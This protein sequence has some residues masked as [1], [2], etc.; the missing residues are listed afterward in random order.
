MTL[1]QLPV[2]VCVQISDFPDLQEITLPGGATL[3]QIISSVKS[4]PNSVDMGLNLLQQL[5]PAMAPLMPLFDIVDTL[6]TLQKVAKAIPEI[7]GPPPDPSKIV[8]LLPEL[9]E[10]MQKL[11]KLIPQL[12]VPLMVK[13]ILDVLIA[14][15]EAART[16]F[17]ALQAELQSVTQAA[18]RAAELN[19]HELASIAL[20]SEAN[21]E[22]QAR[23]IVESLA[24]LNRLLTL[25]NLFMQMANLPVLPDFSDIAGKP[26]AQVI[27]PLDTLITALKAA[28]KA[29]PIP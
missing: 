1:H 4:V 18:Q 29:L 27:T 11:L 7:L 14:T 25:V 19:D 8:Q 13:G 12:S 21:I 2:P 28:R 23:N 16:Q 5:Q 10:K 26:L 24:S 3:S 17:L 9:E 20:C 22:R 15:L 6:L